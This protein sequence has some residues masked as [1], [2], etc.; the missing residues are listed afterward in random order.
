VCGSAEQIPRTDDVWRVVTD[1]P[2]HREWDEIDRKWLPR[3]EHPS[4]ALQFD[5]DFSSAWRQHL[6]QL[7]HETA[8]V[9]IDAEAKRTLVFQLPLLAVDDLGL[10]YAH[11]PEG[12]AP[13][14]CSHTSVYLPE[15]ASGN[16]KG[17]KARRKAIR[18]DVARAMELVMGDLPIEGPPGA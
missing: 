13:P 15:D 3:S 9:L 7:H 12:S 14:A 11:T 5:P 17:A 2:D 10:T 16:G 1:D 4:N 18:L 6:E 8:A